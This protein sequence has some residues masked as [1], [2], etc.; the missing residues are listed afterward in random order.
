M[1]GFARREQGILVA[2]GN[3]LGLGDIASIAKSARAW[4]SV[5][6]APAHN[7]SCSRC[8]RAPASRLDDLAWR[9]PLPDRAGHRQAVR[10]GRADCGIATRSVAL[11]AG[12][13]FLPLAWERF[14]LVVRHRDYFLPAPQAL[15]DFMRWAALRERAMSSAGYDIQ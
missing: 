3:P 11:A 15:F 6:P 7:C 1:I 5:P 13:E 10:A 2:P 4:R 8:W 12:L 14:D 9:S